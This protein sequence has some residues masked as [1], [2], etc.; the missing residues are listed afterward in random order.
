MRPDIHFVVLAAGL[1]LTLFGGSVVMSDQFFTWMTNHIWK[2][3]EQERRLWSPEGI[4]NFNKYGR[5]LG[6]LLGGI[7]LLIYSFIYYVS[8]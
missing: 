4:R 7:I 8:K 6:S 2:G 5:G 1:L 3:S